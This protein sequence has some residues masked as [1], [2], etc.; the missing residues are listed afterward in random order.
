MKLKSFLYIIWSIIFV[1]EMAILANNPSFLSGV[2]IYTCSL[3]AALPIIG[4]AEE[5]NRY[6]K[7]KARM[8]R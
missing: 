5:M 7:I 3:F 1:F 8:V 4:M 2:I 6:K